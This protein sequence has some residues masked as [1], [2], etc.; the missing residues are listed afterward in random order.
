MKRPIL[1]VL[2]TLSAV[3]GLIVSM[4]WLG[5]ADIVHRGFDSGLLL[6]SAAALIYM[7]F[8]PAVRAGS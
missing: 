8:K 5:T 1:L 7:A 2:G 4:G 6:L 3:G